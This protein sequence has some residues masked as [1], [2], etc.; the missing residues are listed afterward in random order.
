MTATPSGAQLLTRATARYALAGEPQAAPRRYP[1]LDLIRAFSALSILIF[2]VIVLARWDTFPDD[3]PLLWFR[4]S[5][6][7][8]DLFFVVSGFVITLAALRERQ[9]GGA[10]RRRF[11]FK[12]IVRLA[13]AYFVSSAAWLMVNGVD[14]LRGP[15]GLFQW[16]THLTL[17]FGFFPGAISTING[18]TW[19]IGIEVQIYLLIALLMPMLSRWVPWRAG[20]LAVLLALCWRLGSQMAHLGAL[21]LDASRVHASLWFWSVQAPGMWDVFGAGLAMALAAHRGWI[22]PLSS[23]RW[24]GLAMATLLYSTALVAVLWTNMAHYWSSYFWGSGYRSFVV[25][26]VLAWLWLAIAMPRAWMDAIPRWA[27]YPGRIS[28]G[29]FLWHVPVAQW[30]IHHTSLTEWALLAACIAVTG[31]VAAASW[32]WIEQPTIA[33]ARRRTHGAQQP[34]S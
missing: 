22:R 11:L 34:S 13:P 32:H 30:L 7:R 5:F 15:D 14:V 24:I 23:W 27:L 19:T 9:R 2:H 17:T 26:M 16:L 1:A 21:Q 28:Y 25:L 12:R 29:V 20:L 18:V 10:A 33:W 6:L 31:V 3:G 8:V 4:V